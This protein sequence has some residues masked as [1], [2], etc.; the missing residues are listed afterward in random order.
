MYATLEGDEAELTAEFEKSLAA[1]K[2]LQD[3]DAELERQILTLRACTK[4]IVQM[5]KLLEIKSM[6]TKLEDMVIAASADIAATKVLLANAELDLVA[7]N[8]RL[9]G[10]I[11]DNTAHIRSCFM[12]LRKHLTPTETTV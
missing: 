5:G 9:V 7:D 3:R 6:A 4:E 10:C 1:I 8:E 2:K 11:H 12:A